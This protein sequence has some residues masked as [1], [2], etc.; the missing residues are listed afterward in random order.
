MQV[1]SLVGK[2]PWKWARQPPPVFLPGESHGQRSPADYSPWGRKELD[3][4][5][6]LSMRAVLPEYIPHA[7]IQAVN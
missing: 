1:R 2:I 5:E 3:T 6:Q 4:T 7:N